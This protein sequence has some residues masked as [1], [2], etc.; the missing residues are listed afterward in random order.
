MLDILLA[1][2]REEGGRQ[3]FESISGRDLLN[4]VSVV[5]ASIRS[6]LLDA[7]TLPSTHPPDQ[8]LEKAC[9]QVGAE[10]NRDPVRTDELSISM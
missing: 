10:T 7:H 9:D 2:G 1:R 5:C 4:D 8:N 6:M 3:V